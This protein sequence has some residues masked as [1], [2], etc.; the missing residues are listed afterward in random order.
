MKSLSDTLQ[1]GQREESSLEPAVLEMISYV[2]KY[3]GDHDDWVDIKIEIMNNLRPELRKKFSRRDQVTREQVPSDFDR[4]V[5][6]QYKKVS[7]VTLVVRTLAERRTMRTG[8]TEESLGAVKHEVQSDT[9]APRG[10][11]STQ[12]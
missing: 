10:H 2:A 3:M 1:E 11:C 8:L 4:S 6:E 5:W 7:G 9:F 12:L